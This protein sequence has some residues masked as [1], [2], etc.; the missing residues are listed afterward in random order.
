[1]VP[2]YEAVKPSR[3]CVFFSFVNRN[4]SIFF[5]SMNAVFLSYFYV[6]SK[7]FPLINFKNV[8]GSSF[9][10]VQNTAALVLIEFSVSGMGS[11]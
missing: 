2:L 3:A 11:F 10:E 1:M 5:G 4:S 8:T 9:S 6:N 7:S